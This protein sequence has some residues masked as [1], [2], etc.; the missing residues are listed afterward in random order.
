M[1]G[2]GLGPRESTLE[3]VILTTTLF[4]FQQDELGVK[5]HYPSSEYNLIF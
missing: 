1:V 3:P 4:Y 2:L 5:S